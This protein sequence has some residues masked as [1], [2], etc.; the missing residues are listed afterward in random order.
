MYT[1]D[2]KTWRTWFYDF[3][4]SKTNTTA[5]EYATQLHNATREHFKP[6]MTTK[7]P[8]ILDVIYE[9]LLLATLEYA[10]LHFRQ[11]SLVTSCRLTYITEL[12]RAMTRRVCWM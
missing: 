12:R 10:S 9:A 7:I 1:P 5:T 6:R 11:L 4:L 2:T 3:L 8:P